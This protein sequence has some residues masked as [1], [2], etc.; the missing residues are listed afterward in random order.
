LAVIISLAFLAKERLAGYAA[1]RHLTPLVFVFAAFLGL[2]LA[3]DHIRSRAVKASLLALLLISSSINIYEGFRFNPSQPYA[4]LAS[5]LEKE[6]LTYGYS[7]FFKSNITTFLSGNKV[8][9][10]PL[11]CYGE[12]CRPFYWQS[13]S[14]WFRPSLHDGPTFLMIPSSETLSAGDNYETLYARPQLV[15]DMFG[16][17][18][19]TLT[20]EDLLIY[21]WPYNILERLLG[22]D[23]SASTPRTT[24]N[25]EDTPTGAI[26]Y[27]RKGES[28]ALVYGNYWPL[29]RG[30]YMAVFTVWAEGQEGSE[31]ATV[32]VSEVDFKA[33]NY[34]SMSYVEPVIAGE[35]PGWRKYRIEFEST[36]HKDLR[37]EC[38]VLVN[39]G[40]EVRVK[41][42]VVE[43]LF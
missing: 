13:K 31:V 8:K 3:G 28:G 26:I 11:F 29:D 39:G 32:D 5:F 16:K 27:S 42:I 19:R 23:I 7:S 25:L 41:S 35:K 33:K 37:Y 24:G 38:R 10:R 12:T 36:G 14:D 9:V 40:G 17:P 4:G 15:A 34:T 22:V 1:A 43:K 18:S 21:E 30:K 2:S 6:N 20:Y